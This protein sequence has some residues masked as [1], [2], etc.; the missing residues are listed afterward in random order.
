EGGRSM[1]ESRERQRARS[2][3]V[4]AQVALALVL[5]ISSGLMIRTFRALTR[6]DPGFVAPSE[7]QTF[8]VDIPETQVKE[9]ER[10]VRI[11][12]EILQKVEAI[13]I[14]GVSSAGV[15]MSV[16]MDGNEWSDAVFAKDRTYAPGEV[17]L[18]RYRFVAPGYFKTLGTPLV[19]GR[20]L[21]WSDI[22]NKVPV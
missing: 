22:Y 5:L 10:V 9:P 2:A 16:P 6:V 17:P 3:L 20:D 1:S 21:T 14:P 8:R 7:V 12:E 11:Q 13:P 19:A 15:S 4:I 18:H